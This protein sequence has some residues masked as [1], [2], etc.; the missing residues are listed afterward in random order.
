LTAAAVSRRSTADSPLRIFRTAA[1][2]LA[3]YSLIRLAVISASGVSAPN[4]AFSRSSWR[5]SASMVR[6]RAL[7]AR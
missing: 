1:S 6:F 3:L 7:L 5:R 4:S 2:R